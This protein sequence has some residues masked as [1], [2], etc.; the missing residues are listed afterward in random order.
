M[1]YFAAAA[2]RAKMLSLESGIS[3][4]TGYSIEMRLF[5]TSVFSD[6]HTTGSSSGAGSLGGW[7]RENMSPKKGDDV[8]NTNLWT[9]K[10][11]RSDD[12]RITSALG[13]SEYFG[14]EVTR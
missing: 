12:W 6:R 13:I 1:S 7:G 10:Q 9:R 11:T 3:G 14:G 2:S 8:T 5:K 4:G